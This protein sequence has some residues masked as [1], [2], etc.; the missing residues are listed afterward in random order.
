MRLLEEARE[1]SCRYLLTYSSR[2]VQSSYSYT[3]VV[4]LDGC[5]PSV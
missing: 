4:M 2:A 3:A 1:Y 5:I